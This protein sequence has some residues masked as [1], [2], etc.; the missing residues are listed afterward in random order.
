MYMYI[1]NDCVLKKGLVGSSSEWGAFYGQQWSLAKKTR[2]K[3]EKIRQ[4]HRQIDIINTT[5]GQEVE[6]NI[7]SPIGRQ[8]D[9]W[10][11]WLRSDQTNRRATNS[12]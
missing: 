1:Q 8:M 12:L 2:G 6:K 4:V 10:N 9:R 3:R 11:E 7:L 5:A